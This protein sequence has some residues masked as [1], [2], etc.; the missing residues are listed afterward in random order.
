ML[1]RLRLPLL[2]LGIAW[3]SAA[4]AGFVTYREIFCHSGTDA[5]AFSNGQ[6]TNG[7]SAHIA[8]YLRRP[9]LVGHIVSSVSTGT[10][11]NTVAAGT[12]IPVS[13]PAVNA[14]PQ[15]SNQMDRGFAVIPAASAPIA[16]AVPNGS[17]YIH[18]TREYSAS[19][20]QIEAFRWYQG[21]HSATDAWQV[22][23][24]IDG[25]AWFV[26]DAAFTNAPVTSGSAFPNSGAARQ[27]QMSGANWRSLAFNGDLGA[28]SGS[29][30]VG[31][32]AVPAGSSVTAFGLFTASKTNN[33]RFD[34]FEIVAVPEPS[35]LAL[36]SIG[37]VGIVGA[38]RK[39][40]RT[41]DRTGC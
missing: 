10:P 30:A 6:P 12:G 4:H 15:Q 40:V 29:M 21:N 36:L 37:L 13:L 26:S 34:T 28:N 9:N 18:Y 22:A 38:R 35:S 1:G 25:G 33:M 27:L 41:M 24:E 17:P 8:W 7:G 19:L 23:I 32:L 11:V 16:D 2:A 5:P 3:A 31:G 39:A 14:G 20:S